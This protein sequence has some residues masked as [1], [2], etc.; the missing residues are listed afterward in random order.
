MCGMRLSWTPRWGVDVHS[1]VHK[2]VHTSRFLEFLEPRRPG[3][4][5]PAQPRRRHAGA[6]PLRPG[7]T[8]EITMNVAGPQGRPGCASSSFCQFLESPEM[9][10]CGLAGRSAL[11]VQVCDSMQQSVVKR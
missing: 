4:S 7:A 2:S 11:S 8:H 10:R 5:R 6:V 3:Q 1:D 9:P